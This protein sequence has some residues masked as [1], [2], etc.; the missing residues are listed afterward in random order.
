MLTLQDS[1]AVLTGV[2]PKMLEDLNKL[3]IETIEDLME[4]FPFRYE[5]IKE[6]EIQEIGDGEKVV[7]KGLITS[8]GIV[9]HFG[10]KKSR[11]NF[12]MMQDGAVIQVTFFNQ[13]YLAK[14]IEIGEEI[15]V[16]GKWD[17]K[18]KALTGIK[19]I[20]NQLSDDFQAIYHV[21]K[22]LP[23]G[24]LVKL[25]QQAFEKYGD[26]IEESL[27]EEIIQQEKLLNR[28]ESL[29]EMH[30]P[31][32][33]A[34]SQEAYRRMIFEEFFYF[35]LKI[36]TLKL[37]EQK[38]NSGQVIAFDNQKLKAFIQTLPFELTN[39]QKRVTNEICRDLL[40]PFHMQRLLQGDVGSGKTIV[41]ALGMYAAITAG[42]QTALMVPTEI[43]AQ[44]HFANFIE[45]FKNQEDVRCALLTSSTK[46]KERREILAGLA[47][48]EIN[49]VIGT[50][51]LIQEDV[52]FSDLGFV[53]TDEQ[54]R[55]GVKQR[56]AF[57][58][59]G[60]QPDVL[61]MTATPIPRTLAI[62]AYG[63]MDVSIINEL[64]KGRKPILTKWVKKEQ[65]QE[66][67]R[68]LRGKIAQGDQAYFVTP[69]I[70]ESETLD[71]KNAQEL[72]QQIQSYFPEFQVGLLHGQMKNEEKEA[73]M[74]AFK[75]KEFQ[76]LVA[77]TV[78]EVGV[79]VPNATMMVI[80]DADR[81]GLAQLHQ[82]RGRVGRGQKASLCVLVANPKGEN[83]KSR[84]KIMTETND[85][86]VLS[87]K[88][89]EM[90]GP[91][92]FFGKRQSGLPQFHVADL[93]RDTE[94]LDHVQNVVKQFLTTGDAKE[95]LNQEP[96]KTKLAQQVFTSYFD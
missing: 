95:K 61:F 34:L 83:G 57:R 15:A 30:F 9:S 52:L 1:V 88:D 65:F 75:Q 42:K 18:R 69:L 3:E 10:Y 71:L 91:G 20:A 40:A 24:K 11:L 48:G 12:R 96:L 77:T 73:V 67:L 89:L 49:L 86:F 38:K 4:Y 33:E 94:V 6:R 81:F 39:A 93:A 76:I 44:Q 51:A 43:L 22:G 14:K 13:P 17:A 70:E 2:G 50:H 84:M 8:P 45:L 92:E 54:H 26:V 58:E 21:T 28:K 64:P 62:T 80:L 78:I 60:S 87:Q 23:Q 19:V 16:F 66:V 25:I 74:A 37:K 79:D 90:R 5:D 27:P 46:T 56:K 59:K 41:C 47:S 85:G 32:S 53:V 82:L 55:F 31:K 7:L 63:E 29:F 68:F 35:Q 72:Y 36:W